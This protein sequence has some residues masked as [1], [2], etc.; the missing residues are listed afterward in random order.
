M[1]DVEKAFK[2]LQARWGTVREAGMM[3]ESETLWLMMICCVIFHS[4]IVDDKGDGVA[5][6]NN[7]EMPGE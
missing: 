3:W 4:M 7:F 6:T 1:K 5:Q 2:V